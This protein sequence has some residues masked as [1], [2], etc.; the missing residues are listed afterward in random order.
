MGVGRDGLGC[1][2]ITSLEMK[3][4]SGKGVLAHFWLTSAPGHCFTVTTGNKRWKIKEVQR[5][6][7]MRSPSCAGRCPYDSESLSC[8][9]VAVSSINF[10]H[11]GT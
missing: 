8:S 9:L 3:K 5:L 6:R 11:R 2:D 4:Y 10:E 1:I 7:P